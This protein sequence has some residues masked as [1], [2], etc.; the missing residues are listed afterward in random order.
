MNTTVCIF[1]KHLHWLDYR[2]MAETAARCGF[3][4]V[5]L[6][7]RPEGHVLPERVEEDLPRA[8]EEI[9]K[10][11]LDVPM[12]TTAILSAEDPATVRI[13]RTASSL[14]IP[15]YRPG[16][17]DYN[18]LRGVDQELERFGEVFREL[19]ALNREYRI[20]GSYQNHAGKRV[21][22]PV[23][24]LW[25]LL[26]KLD[27]EWMGCQYDIRHAMVEGANSWPLAL[28]LVRPHINSLVI[29]DFGW[30]REGP[31]WQA[32]SLP[33]GEGMVDFHQFVSLL[34]TRISSIPISV[35]LEYPLGGADQGLPSLSIPTSTVTDAMARDCA[36]VKNLLARV[37]QE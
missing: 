12:L 2:G 28:D 6:T 17:L 7:V 37:E 11:G 29:K 15:L 18:P 20:R 9:R 1:S 22:A 32:K 35:H 14:R 30:F 24:D 8:V 3:D 16:W 33:L 26:T 36:F 25:V 23:W 5:D 13:L 10:A 4:G 21:G 19:E 34:R 27:S 31:Q